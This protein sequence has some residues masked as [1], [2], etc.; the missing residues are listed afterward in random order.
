MA[1]KNLKLLRETLE[2]IK[3]N[4]ARH[5]QGAWVAA[6]DDDTGDVVNELCETS[7]CFAGHAAL[8]AGG[9]FD[10]KVYAVDFEWNVDEDGKARRVRLGR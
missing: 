1:E 10:I 7:M 6:T 8:L 3:K 2:F 5:N 9:T 4:P